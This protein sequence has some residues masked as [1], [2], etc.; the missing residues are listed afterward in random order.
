MSQ[1]DFPICKYQ[2]W[3]ACWTFCYCKKTDEQTGHCAWDK[4]CYEE[5]ERGCDE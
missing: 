1:D 5:E 3:S 2:Y 4:K